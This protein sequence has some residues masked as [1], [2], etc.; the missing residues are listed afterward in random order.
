[1][2]K[3]KVK[4]VIVAAFILGAVTA[5]VYYMS[6]TPEVIDEMRE[7]DNVIE[8]LNNAQSDFKTESAEHKTQTVRRVVEIREAV[9]QEV[10]ALGPDSLARF[11]LGEIELWRSGTICQGGF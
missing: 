8:G 4:Y 6:R 9:R 2:W 10:L 3:I 1:M 5:A 7:T 11:A